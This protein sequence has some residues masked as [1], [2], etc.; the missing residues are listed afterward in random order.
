MVTSDSSPRDASSNLVFDPCLDL[1]S[2]NGGKRT[3]KSVEPLVQPD[4]QHL[5]DDN[6]VESLELENQFEISNEILQEKQS[7][8]NKLYR[9][10]EENTGD[11][12][13][14]VINNTLTFTH[15]I[16]N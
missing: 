3:P 12:F 15:L 16:L 5:V 7:L 11:S 8:F 10:L 13:E 6:F 14:Q 9:W 4:A 2:N 1:K